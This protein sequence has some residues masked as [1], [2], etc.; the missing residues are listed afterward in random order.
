VKPVEDIDPVQNNVNDYPEATSEYQ[1]YI[2]STPNPTN[3][4]GC[5]AVPHYYDYWQLSSVFLY[6]FLPLLDID[7]YADY[8]H[9]FRFDM[10][11]FAYVQS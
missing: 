10:V 4:G 11:Y 2:T 1:K 8:H 3:D 7:V 5:N 6:K 9:P